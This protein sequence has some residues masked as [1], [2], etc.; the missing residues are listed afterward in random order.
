LTE[1]TRDWD[2]VTYDRVSD[3]QEQW[4]RDVLDRLPLRGDE[5]VLDAGCGSGRVT[6]MLLERLPRGYVVAV[7]AAP[8]MVEHAR[9]RLDPQRATVFQSDLL[10]LSLDEPVDA[11]FSNAVLHWIRD[12]D[13]VLGR[14]FRA[15]RPG[16]RFVAEFGGHTNI[17]AISVAIRAVVE[18]HQLPYERPWYY[19]TAD[20]YRTRLE[21]NGFVVDDI[22]LFPRPTPL[23]TGM[24]G[25]LRTF[26]VS[27]FTEIAPELR[28]QVEEEIVELL[29][30]ALCDRSGQWTADYVR[31]QFVAS[32]RM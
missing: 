10:E 23:P 30:P 13:A 7:D 15:L 17:A 28:L 25:W 29:R 4:A 19:P 20:E 6:E 1:W 3:V 2:A 8:S 31:L 27:L 16:G 32:K 24:T 11:V 26:A 14:V 21:A 9:E 18:R 22:R 5:R 12:A